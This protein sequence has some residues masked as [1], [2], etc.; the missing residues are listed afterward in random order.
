[1]TMLTKIAAAA[2]LGSLALTTSTHAV[3]MTTPIQSQAFSFGDLNTNTNLVF[4][5]FNGGLGTLLEVMISFSADVTLNNTAAVVPTGT[6]DKIVGSLMGG[7]SIDLT[8]TAALTASIPLFFMTTNASLS[9]PGFTGV[10]IDDNSVQ[11]VG[12]ITSNIA[13]SVSI[14]N[15]FLLPNYIGGA[16]LYSVNM[17]SSGTQGGSVPAGVLTGNTGTANGSVNVQYLYDDGTV[18]SPEPASMAILGAG[19]AGIGLL[20]RRRR[21]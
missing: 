9:T 7:G 1:M 16:A 20:R 15:P 18:A 10:V 11:T 4:S 12:T 19:L 13:N 8:A 6:G 3:P 21:G 2:L 17:A 14:T 5:G